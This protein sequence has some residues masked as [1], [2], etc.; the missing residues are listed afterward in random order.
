MNECEQHIQPKEDYWSLHAYRNRLAKLGS[1][2][3]VT[4]D[5]IVDLLAYA[6]VL[7]KNR[8]HAQ[9]LQEETSTGTAAVQRNPRRNR[10]DFLN[11]AAGRAIRLSTINHTPKT[12][13]TINWCI[14]CSCP[15][16][17]NYSNPN[18]RYRCSCCTVPRCLAVYS[19]RYVTVGGDG[20]VGTRWLRSNYARTSQYPPGT[21]CLAFHTYWHS[22]SPSG[23]H[24]DEE[25]LFSRHYGAGGDTNN[26]EENDDDTVQSHLAT[27]PVHTT[28]RDASR[29]RTTPPARSPSAR[30]RTRTKRN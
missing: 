1:L 6:D 25:D 2:N 17:Q 14:L 21:R 26:E 23:D 30:L 22:P 15:R 3:E 18:S 13:E 16:D 20:T 28:R 29:M 19:A 9:R 12:T 27:P 10:F 7:R 5:L 24:E 11:T 8:E 4:F